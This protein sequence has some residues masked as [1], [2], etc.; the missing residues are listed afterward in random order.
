MFDRAELIVERTGGLL[1][2]CEP[3]ALK[4]FL[5]AHLIFDLVFVAWCVL[6]KLH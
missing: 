2:K 4:V 5:L 3:T 6:T 1:T